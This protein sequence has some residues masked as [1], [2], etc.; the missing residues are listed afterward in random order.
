MGGCGGS[1]DDT[2]GAPSPAPAPHPAASV[3]AAW[4]HHLKQF[5][6]M[7]FDKILLDYD[8]DSQIGVFNDACA[9]A[10]QEKP[11]GYT[12]YKGTAEIK[13]FFTNLFAQL[14]QNISNA[15]EFG[16]QNF[17]KEGAG[18]VVKEATNGVAYGNVFLTWRTQNLGDKSIDFATDSF[19]FKKVGENFRI[20]LQTIV[21]TEPSG[22][23]DEATQLPGPKEG[24]PLKKGWDNHLKCFGARDSNTSCMMDDYTDSSIVQV[25]DNTQDTYEVFEGLDKIQGMFVSL[26]AA[27]AAE[28]ETQGDPTTEGLEVRLLEVDETFSSVFLVWESNSHPKATDTFTFNGDKITRQNIVVTTK[29]AST[30]A[31]QVLTETERAMVV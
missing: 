28:A 7:D 9:G 3:Q 11:K 6:E 13:T 12:T 31:E 8:E 29:K 4:D 1:S 2:T 15:H 25:W 16:P 30:E 14:Q 20:N 18:A 27:M 21:V 24:S 17:G 23:C 26:F 10:D 19:S 5:V 22:K